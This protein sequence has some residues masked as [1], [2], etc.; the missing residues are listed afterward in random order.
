MNI[1]ELDKLCD[2]APWNDNTGSGETINSPDDW[3]CIVQD[4]DVR[5]HNNTMIRH[6]RNNFMRAL[7]ALKRLAVVADSE[8]P[9]TDERHPD[10]DGTNKLIKELETVI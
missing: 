6:C 3:V 8:Y 10:N 1:Y 7:E 4:N 9:V 2:P 5:S